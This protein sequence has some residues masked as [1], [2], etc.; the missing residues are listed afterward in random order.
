MKKND[1]MRQPEM[2]RKSTYK[3]E[4][5]KPKDPV[6][7]TKGESRNPIMPEPG[8]KTLAER[9]GAD[10]V[11]T[12]K[13]LPPTSAKVIKNKTPASNPYLLPPRAAHHSKRQSSSDSK[14]VNQNN[15]ARTFEEQ[16][17]EA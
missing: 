16:I 11:H 5:T 9:L 17:A 13:I 15:D 8:P 14:G 6:V 1:G 2:P 3:I 10:K 12:I 4:A 7:K